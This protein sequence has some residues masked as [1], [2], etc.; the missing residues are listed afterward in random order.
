LKIESPG[1]AI[2]KIICFMALQFEIITNNLSENTLN[3]LADLRIKV[4]LDFP[5][6][7]AG[8]M[9]YEKEYLNTY[10]NAEDSILILVKNDQKIVGAST[11][12]PM[13]HETE[14]VKAP[15]IKN[16]YDVNEIF[17]F[18]ESV[19]LPEY[20]GQGIGLKFFELREEHAKTLGGFEL[21]TF[22]GVVRPEDH[23]LKPKDYVPLDAFWNKRGYQKMNEMYCSMDWKDIDEEEETSKPLQFWS[24][25]I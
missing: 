21:C 7:Y 13:K 18:G 5:Y 15:W 9:D 22:C 23:P 1:N 25:K 24:K 11:A 12:L 14:N 2:S 20:R 4:F 3:D 16:G 17:Y 10:I 8:D 6:L 19:V